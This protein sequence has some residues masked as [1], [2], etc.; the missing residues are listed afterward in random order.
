MELVKICWKVSG[1]IVTAAILT[2]I[3]FMA[4][5]TL[6]ASM[7]QLDEQTIYC[8]DAIIDEANGRITVPVRVDLGSEIGDQIRMEMLFDET[9]LSNPA[10]TIGGDYDVDF[11]KGS[12]DDL[13]VAVFGV[14]LPLPTGDVH[15][16]DVTF[17]WTGQKTTLTFNSGN[18]NGDESGSLYYLVGDFNPLQ[19]ESCQI[20][21]DPV[22]YCGEISTDEV[23]GRATLPVHVDF[24]SN[25]SDQVRMEMAFDD[26]VLSNPVATLGDDF[27][28]SFGQD[29][30][31]N[32]FGTIFGRSLTLGGDATGD[33][34]YA[35]FTFDWTGDPTIITFNPSDPNGAESGSL[36]YLN[37]VFWPMATEWCAVG[38]GAPTPTPTPTNTPTATPTHTP[39]NT[40]TST[41][42][43]TPTNTNTPTITPT[44]TNTNTPTITPTPTDTSTPTI[45]PTPSNTPTP[46]ITPTPFPTPAPIVI[47]TTNVITELVTITTTVELSET[48]EGTVFLTGTV[49][50]TETV[51]ITTA[52]PITQT[53]V[54][55]ETASVTQV[56]PTGSV[57]GWFYVSDYGRLE[58][59]PGVALYLG[60]D[61]AVTDE[62]G[63]Y[64]FT[65]LPLGDYSAWLDS[66]TLPDD[67]FDI[68]ESPPGFSGD[69]FSFTASFDVT[70]TESEPNLSEQNFVFSSYNS[71][72]SPASLPEQFGT[73]SGIIYSIEAGENVGL[74]GVVVWLLDWDDSLLDSRRTDTDGRYEFYDLPFDMY[75][76][77]VD[78]STLPISKQGL[79]PAYAP[80]N[81]AD[82]SSTFFVGED[83]FISN[84]Q[85]FGYASLRPTS[86]TIAPHTTTTSPHLLIIATTLFSLL[87][88]IC[89]RTAVS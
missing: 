75:T 71:F 58:G 66:Q 77:S 51:I 86:V 14:T 30:L 72:P 62:N 3:L 26:A 15:F 74:E 82:S 76:V 70:L 4:S 44:P 5:G 34:H 73:V 43:H 17:D 85:S 79:P 31:G 1:F 57:S 69:I 89:G 23:N 81:G 78:E 33:T 18:P 8:G 25:F 64:S 47:T 27:D 16:A 35:D 87:T 61:V 60:G 38:E 84:F 49:V 22:I 7:D 21:S 36:S 19:T 68:L 32:L 2:M 88:I 48:V 65:T 63:F 45:T 50:V 52:V 42:T 29:T 13:V 20:G 67:L 55:T 10:V 28:V 6:F 83:E 41:P 56:V 40:P 37:G 53:V 46:T 12:Q 59:I 11:G 54:I 24:G 9:A 39:T 80:D